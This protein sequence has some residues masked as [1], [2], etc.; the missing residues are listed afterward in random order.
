M[1]MGFPESFS[2]LL[3]EAECTQIDQ[4]LLPTRDRF[5]IR[6]TVYAWRYLQQLAE[7][8]GIKVAE[9]TPTQIR[10]KLQED[11]QLQSQENFDESFVGW[12]GNLLTSSLGPIQTIAQE[13]QLEIE[14]L[15]FAQIVN[16]FELRV[17]ASQ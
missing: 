15:S 4:T 9:L 14:Q 2:G 17:K 8:L 12:F 10:A 16:W 3:T 13:L 7:E 6:I 11:P 5:S 1:T